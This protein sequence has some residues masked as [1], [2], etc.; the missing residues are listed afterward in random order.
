MTT[1]ALEVE[2]LMALARQKS[3][4]ARSQ[5]FEV[6]GDIFLERGTVLS[7]QERALMVDILEKLIREVS[8]EIRRKLALKLAEAPG[9]PRE[10]A[11]LLANDDIDIASPILLK[12][13]A[14]EDVDLIEIIRN[15]SIQHMLAISMRRDL[16]TAV[17]DALVEHGG[18][19][20]IRSLLE[21]PDAQIG[22]A[23]MAY[24]VEQSRAVDEFQEPLARRQDLPRDLAVRMCF[25]VSAAIR[26]YI[27]EKFEIDK[28]TLDDT[29]EPL[30]TEF[31]ASLAE[32]KRQHGAADDL[33][34]QLGEQRKLTPRLLIQTLRRG[35][36]PLFEAMMA[37]MCDLR[38][39]L[40]R[41]IC[42]EPGAEGLAVAAR[43]IGL[44][45]EEFATIYLLTRKAKHGPTTTDPGD[46]G[47]V[48]VFFDRVS[49]SNA[50]A[51]L[52]RW[53]RD[54][55]YLFAIKS[56]EESQGRQRA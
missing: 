3:D 50:E 25:W 22:R 36:I 40:V 21:N 4:Q 23:T 32:E 49:H 47:R 53:R 28:D 46:L 45:R 38:V 7:L 54:P 44:S 19:D 11:V 1:E 10:L 16:S 39:N 37:E 9:T 51:V 8:Q 43:A 17:A 5:L 34:R 55:N 27:V 14:L 56:I 24:L 42:Y 30:T 15:R 20:V 12:C 33:A 2:E 52:N 41:R 31:A 18:N 29:L 26:Q 35:E 48:L 13:K 6:M